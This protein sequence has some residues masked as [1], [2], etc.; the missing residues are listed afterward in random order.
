MNRINSIAT[1]LMIYLFIFA[2]AAMTIET[3]GTDSIPN[4]VRS[5]LG[6]LT[7]VWLISVIYLVF[8][9]LF[10][11]NL[12]N[13]FARKIAGI[14]ENDEREVII[15]GNASKKTFI[16]M[17]SAITVLLFM[18]TFSFD[19]KTPLIQDGDHKGSF[20]VGFGANFMKKPAPITASSPCD[21]PSDGISKKISY[22]G[23]PLTNDAVLMLILGL[24]IGAFYFFSNKEHQI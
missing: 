15:A 5:I 11:K 20:S 18:S 6:S 23:L 9:L 8:A 1:K 7:L 10:S 3:L 19:V 4:I 22:S 13:N 14:K 17:I 12:R 21:T 16:F 2:L 24:Q